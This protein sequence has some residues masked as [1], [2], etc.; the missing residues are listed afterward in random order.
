MKVSAAHLIAVQTQLNQSMCL[1]PEGVDC[2]GFIEAHGGYVF[3]VYT[4]DEMNDFDTWLD[5][6]V[7]RQGVEWHS[8]SFLEGAYRRYV[9]VAE[10]AASLA[11]LFWC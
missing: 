11:R 3:Y 8:Y 5:E 9:L 4:H 10:E 1:A 2:A 7:G 6:N